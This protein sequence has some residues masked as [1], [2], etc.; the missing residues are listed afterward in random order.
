[1]ALGRAIRQVSGRPIGESW[2]F[3]DRD[4]LESVVDGGPLNGVGLHH[5]YTHYRRPIFGAAG[6]ASKD[7]GFPLIVK[8][9]DARETL[10]VQVHPPA[11]LAGELGGEPKG[12]R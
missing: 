5:L 9:L 8:L 7:K 12:L 6:V 1:M 11:P 10:S 2:E 4:D 3:V